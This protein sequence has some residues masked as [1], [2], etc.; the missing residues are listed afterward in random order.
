MT[1]NSLLRYLGT[2]QLRRGRYQPRSHFDE[3]ALNELAQSIQSQGLIQ[4]IVVRP[5]DHYYEIIAGER[6]WRA[7]QIAGLDT[8]PCLIND[9]SD[10]QAAAV[11]TIENVQ[12]RD[13]NPIEEAKALQRLV[14]EFNY[15]HEEI[16]AILGKSR[17]HVTNSLRLLRL[18]TQIQNWLIAGKLTE[19]HGKILA[20]LNQIEQVELAKLCISNNWSVRHLEQKSKANTSATT[21]N[22]N[23]DTYRLERILSDHFGSKVTINLHE[24]GG[25]LNIHFFDNDILQGL[26]QKM[27]IAKID[28]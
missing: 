8:V 22:S 19:G 5:C 21:K 28:L 20:G 13:L 12:R 18:D 7:A 24:K 25:W 2:E 3:T 9:Y 11:T 26:L 10:Q 23:A 17:S 16:A 4:P 15:Q 1:S 14:D 6:R 27:G